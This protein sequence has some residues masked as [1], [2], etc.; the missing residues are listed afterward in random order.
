[1]MPVFSTGRTTA[2]PPRSSKDDATAWT[3]CSFGRIELV[4]IPDLQSL[5][6]PVLRLLGNG[7]ERVTND[8]V[9]VVAQDFRLSSDEQ[10]QPITSGRQTV[11]FNRVHWAVTYLFKA[12]LIDRTGTGKIQITNRGKDVLGRQPERISF[13]D[14]R[15]YPEFVAFQRGDTSQGQGAEPPK[16]ST[17]ETEPGSTPILSPDEVIDRSYRIIR[18]TLAQE[19]LDTV[20]QAS[21]AFFERLVVDLLVAMGYGGSRA[22]AG[23][24]IGKSGDEGIDGIIKEDKLGLDSVYIQAKR[25]DSSVSRP[26]VQGFAGALEGQRA[27]K[28]V[29]ITT[30]QFTKEALA[31]VRQIEKRIVLIDGDQL[32]QLMLDHGIGVSDVATYRIQRLDLAYFGDG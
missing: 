31:Y 1:M 13:S 30:S 27:R 28:G 9:P 2:M 15:Q 19:L 4:A 16:D 26:T 32:S 25:W 23:Q 22:D 17:E 18:S 3:L 5:T 29:F 12:G 11:L 20:K 7:T 10:T 14:L 24:A 8:L 21:P 6:L